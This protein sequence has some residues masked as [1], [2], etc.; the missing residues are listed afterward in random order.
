MV[1]T[2]P[3]AF[4]QVFSL[5]RRSRTTSSPLVPLPGRIRLLPLPGPPISHQHLV[6][7]WSPSCRHWPSVPSSPS[8]HW[9]CGWPRVLFVP[10]LYFWEML[11]LH[12]LCT[13]RLAS[14]AA[15]PR[16]PAST[17]EEAGGRTV[18]PMERFYSRTEGGSEGAERHMAAVGFPSLVGAG[19]ADSSLPPDPSLALSWAHWW[20]HAWQPQCPSPSPAGLGAPLPAP[21]AGWQCRLVR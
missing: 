21:S 5:P 12:V 1:L 14:L 13:A 7:P 19:I 11:L 6:S 17:R 15:L 9:P 4:V 10:S 18:L 8:Q 16:L 3:W 20:P 2:H